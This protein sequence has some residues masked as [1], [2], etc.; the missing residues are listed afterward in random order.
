MSGT[1]TYIERT[2]HIPADAA[3]PKLKHNETLT[4]NLESG[5]TLGY[6]TYGST[7]PS[8]PTIFLLH[9]MPGSRICG[10]SFHDACLKVGARLI[11]IDRPGCGNST[12]APRTLIQWPEDVLALADHLEIDTFSIIG[13]SSGASFALACACYLPATRLL[14]TMLVCGIG[15]VESLGWIPWALM[16]V[17]PWAIR[18]FAVH[19]LLPRLLG[20]YIDKNAEQLKDLIE[21]QCTTLEEKEQ[22]ATEEGQKGLDDT[23]LQYV[24]AFKQGRQGPMHDGLLL[25]SGWGFRVEDI[26]G[27]RVRVI[28]GDQDTHAPLS[29]AKWVDGKLGGGRLQVLE[30][31]THFTIWKKCGEE[32]FSWAAGN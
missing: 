18:L 10:R 25:S 26:N 17:A 6:A 20:P 30:G 12:F 27:D 4:L 14:R 31:V 23:V 3:S 2:P 5:R 7:L 15:P 21:S 22:V 29:M 32:V 8:A 19:F 1:T 24:E 16:R 13:A 28:H 9:G 11:T